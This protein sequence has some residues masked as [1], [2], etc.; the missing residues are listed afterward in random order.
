MSAGSHGVEAQIETKMMSLGGGIITDLERFCL[1]T[2]EK[3]H[4][5]ENGTEYFGGSI[6]DDEP[7]Y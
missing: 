5:Y 1:G 7:H 4:D 2:F 6:Y 3:H